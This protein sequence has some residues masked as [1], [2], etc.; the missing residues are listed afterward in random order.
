[1]KKYFL[2]FLLGLSYSFSVFALS[3]IGRWL[4][5]DDA[6]HQPRSVVTIWQSKD[7]RYYGKIDEIYLRQGEKPSDVCTECSGKWHNKPFVGIEIINGL[8]QTDANQYA[9]GTILDPH[10]GKTYRCR[11][12][13]EKNG[14]VL[15]VRGYIGIP[16]LGR[17][18][19]W[20]RIVK[21]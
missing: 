5:I 3:P 21:S 6:T 15:A 4:T 19:I 14:K 18:Q 17:T 7:A 9:D 11:L 12:T 20:Q 13:L 1:M 8:K 10:N 2:L 16:L